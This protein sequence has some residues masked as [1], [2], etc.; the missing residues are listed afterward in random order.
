MK[1][2]VVLLCSILV[3]FIHPSCNKKNE[4]RTSKIDL[5]HQL[6]KKLTDVIVV[7][8]FTPPVASRIYANC[9]LSMYEAGRFDED[10]FPSIS[11]KLNGFDPMPVPEKDKKYDF[12]VAAIQAFCETAKKI[13]FSANEMKVY[14][15]SMIGV[16][17]KDLS[18]EVL[19]NSIAFGQKVAD[20]VAK[21]LSTDNYKETRGMDR[22]E[23]KTDDN[24][25]WVPT[26]PDYAD[27][28]EP[29]WY[30]MKSFSLQTP[31]EAK[32]DPY[33]EYNEDTTSPYFRELKEV[34]DISKDLSE[35]Q[36]D[37]AI[38][39]DDNPFVS[40]HKGHV[41]FQDKKMTPGGHW[42]AI[43]R[44]ACMDHHTG[45]VAS[46]K[47]YAYT[48]IG[49]YDAFISCWYEKY[50]SLRIRPQTAIQRL[51]EQQWTS[52]IQTPPFPEYTSG[53]STVSA[54]AAE[55]L[56]HL[57]G[58]G[59]SFTDSSEL[60]YNLPIRSFK[61]YRDA[62]LEASISRVYGGIHYRSGCENGNKL[63]IKVAELAIKKIEQD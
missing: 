1:K 34:Y 33:P 39:W 63:G 11:S 7:D 30:K 19:A 31:D 54:S 38:F 35:N 43:T 6:I 58:D 57:F 61:S 44:K 53:H 25:R 15:D 60:E 9:A 62:A 20:V 27:A 4:R 51:I 32:A 26:L 2:I 52:Y 45:F 22:F 50:K 47:A 40:R 28:L 18:D 41:M 36:I 56:T 21:R 14:Q 23:V 24:K 48:A 42:M 49:L 3:L 13:T 46:S 29:H 55:M 16:Y 17:G 59:Q 8:I 5:P 10:G 37:I 12:S